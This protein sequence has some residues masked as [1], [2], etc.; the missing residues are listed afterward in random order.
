VVQVT[1]LF[2]DSSR[3]TVKNWSFCFLRDLTGSRVTHGEKGRRI[4]KSKKTYCFIAGWR[5]VLFLDS[6]SGDS[7]VHDSHFKLILIETLLGHF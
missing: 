6:V 2:F 4:G 5:R 3:R 1:V 7:S